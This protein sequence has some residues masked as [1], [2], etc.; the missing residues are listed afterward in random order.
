VLW[1]QGFGGHFDWASALVALGAAV[2][3]FR[4]KVGVMPLLAACALIGLALTA[5]PGLIR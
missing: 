5:L 1:P 4:F 3:L 2:A